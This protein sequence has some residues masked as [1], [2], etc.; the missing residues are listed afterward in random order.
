MPRNDI[1]SD[2][3]FS[4]IVP[5]LLAPPPPRPPAPPPP[6]PP[7][8]IA[9]TLEPTEGEALV[10]QLIAHANELAEQLEQVESGGG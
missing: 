9:E 3:L 5:A 7:A 2:S 4:L 8:L 10:Q 1:Q 6:S